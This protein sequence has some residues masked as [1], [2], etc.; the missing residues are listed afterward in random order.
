MLTEPELQAP[1]GQGD[2]AKPLRDDVRELGSILGDTIRRFEGE[3][4]FSYVEQFRGLFKSIHQG[5]LKAVNQAKELAESIRV[6]VASKVIKSFVTYF[7][8]IN[9]AEQNHR[10]RRRAQLKPGTS[11]LPRR[12]SIAALIEDLKV[13]TYPT[14]TC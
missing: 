12:D 9:I 1:D 6:E 11:N 10:V 2:R 13:W 4:I 7:D 5:D 3:Q 14:M 8:L